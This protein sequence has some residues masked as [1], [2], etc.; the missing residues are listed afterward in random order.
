MTLLRTDDEAKPSNICNLQITIPTQL[1]YNH[2]QLPLHFFHAPSL[3][4]SKIKRLY[5]FPNYLDKA[6][7]FNN[8]PPKYYSGQME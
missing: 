3:L 5:K 2:Q 4:V 7:D 1:K 8:I 6:S